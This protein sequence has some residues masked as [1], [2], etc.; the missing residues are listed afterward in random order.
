MARQGIREYYASTSTLVKEHASQKL[1]FKMDL[2][3]D[4]NFET[5]FHKEIDTAYKKHKTFV[6]TNVQLDNFSSALRRIIKLTLEQPHRCLVVVPFH[7]Y[8]DILIASLSTLKEEFPDIQLLHVTHQGSESLN[9]AQVLLCTPEQFSNLIRVREVLTN[10]GTI[11][12]VDPHAYSKTRVAFL[13]GMM[14]RAEWIRQLHDRRQVILCSLPKVPTYAIGQLTCS[15]FHLATAPNYSQEPSECIFPVIQDTDE[16]T[17]PDMYLRGGGYD[18]L[19]HRLS[20][21]LKTDVESVLVFARQKYI[22]WL[23]DDFAGDTTLTGLGTSDI[24]L[25]HSADTV[26]LDYHPYIDDNTLFRACLCAKNHLVILANPSKHR[27]RSNSTLEFLAEFPEEYG[28]TLQFEK[29][30]VLDYLLQTGVITLGKYFFKT[31]LVALFHT[32]RTLNELYDALCTALLWDTTAPPLAKATLR[33][34][35]TKLCTANLLRRVGKHGGHYTTTEDGS[36]VMH[37]YDREVLDKIHSKVLEE[38]DIEN[39]LRFDHEYNL[40]RED[41][42]RSQPEAQERY[43]SFEEMDDAEKA[44]METTLRVRGIPSTQDSKTVS[45]SSISDPT[46]TK[47]LTMKELITQSKL[48]KEFAGKEGK[49]EEEREKRDYKRSKDPPTPLTPEAKT[50]LDRMVYEGVSHPSEISSKTGIPRSTVK[51]YLERQAYKGKFRRVEI[52]GKRGRPQLHYKPPLDDETQD[53]ELCGNCAHYT[54]KRYCNLAFNLCRHQQLPY[55]LRGREKHLPEKNHACSKFV[56]KSGIRTINSFDVTIKS[57]CPVYHCDE[58]KEPIN[59][60]LH[61]IECHNCGTSYKEEHHHTSKR[62]KAYINREDALRRSFRELAGFDLQE[63][64]TAKTLKITKESI[65][66]L[67]ED[68]LKLDKQEISFSAIKRIY[69]AKG[70]LD[71]VSINYLRQK[72]I[73]VK[74]SEASSTGHPQKKRR[75]TRQHPTKKQQ[76]AVINARSIL[77]QPMSLA[78]VLN[79]LIVTQHLNALILPEYASLSPVI[80]RVKKQWDEVYRILQTQDADFLYYY[81]LAEGRSAKEKWGAFRDVIL[82]YYP[83]S[84]RVGAR[85]V[86]EP[87]D[88]PYGYSRAYSEIHAD[89]NYLHQRIT[90]AT[91]DL[92][93]RLG[94]PSQG[95]TGILHTS[96]FIYDVG[97][98]FKTHIQLFLAKNILLERMKQ[99]YH[100]SYRGKWEILVYTLNHI[101]VDILKQLVKEFWEQQVYFNGSYMT[102]QDVHELWTETVLHAIENGETIDPLELMI[103]YSEEEFEKLKEHYQ[104]FEK[105]VTYINS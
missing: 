86:L 29:Q 37:V 60:Y 12:W 96:D 5:P 18:T 9:A 24:W 4:T 90:F 23:N 41:E 20:K 57:G 83:W 61:P 45:K 58:C 76:E 43:A 28:I 17:L 68:T 72:H 53:S 92:L 8:A 67:Q 91:Q 102:M 62:Y 69:A 89:I 7:T 14:V 88:E 47:P 27:S 81:R 50:L 48:K 6:V 93:D 36:K 1:V 40:S 15:E 16:L 54:R 97:D 85:L 44:R 79:E 31:L 11:I 104:L 19:T 78:R 66:T 80:I 26:F 39:E 49:D 2:V 33:K 13:I 70:V 35:L 25:S 56:S 77:I 21:V 52:R 34:L 84:D 73:F 30:Q 74:E 42:V 55:F 38:E 64:P 22:D 46:R 71:A 94:L 59:I 105:Y 63:S 98:S 87:P 3:N 101:G 95:L 103:T 99:E 82:P 100:N 32:Q 51:A 10:I 65:V 75:T